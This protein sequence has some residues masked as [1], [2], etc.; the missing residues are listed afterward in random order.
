MNKKIVFFLTLSLVLSLL[1]G[2]AGTTVVVGEKCTCTPSPSAPAGN[3]CTCTPLPSAPAGNDCTCPSGSHTPSDPSE[4]DDGAVKTGLAVVATISGS[5]NAECA[6]YDVTLV[7]VTVDDQ[8]VIQSCVIDSIGT[9]VAFDATGTI[10]TALDSVIKTKNE[11]GD[12]YGM[13]QY[14]GSKFEWYEQAAALAAY[15]QGKTVEELKSGAIDESGKAPAGSDLASTATIY[16]GGYVGA[17]EKAVANAKH[18]GAQ[19]GDE[20]RLASTSSIASSTGATADKAGTAQLDCD[21]TAV[22][23][24]DG[25][26]TSCYID[27]LQ[28]KVS[29]DATGAI[30]TDLTAPVKTKNELGDEYGMKAY[31]NAKFEWYEQAANF[32]AYVTGKTAAQVAGIAVSEGKPADADLL[33]SVTIAITG[34]QALIAKVMA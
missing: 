1:A 19:A 3:D 22:T 29:F 28:A 34:F 16:L 30:T 10:T 24:K 26:I 18:L 23:V 32:A 27:S 15:A 13:K 17:I 7:A 6:D 33:S 11:L 21:V 20:L 9:K 2:C 12:A 25:A 8:G 31:A 5:K 14:A 4:P